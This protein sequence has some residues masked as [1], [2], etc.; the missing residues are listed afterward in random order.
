MKK[1]VFEI[2]MMFLF[3]FGL[4]AQNSNDF[5]D[6]A[7]E[8]NVKDRFYESA[9]RAGLTEA[10]TKELLKIIEERNM[11]LKDLE[12]KKKQADAPYSIQDSGTLYNFK[13]NTARNYYAQKINDFLTY[14]E[15]SEFAMEDYRNEARENTKSEYQLLIA[16]NTGLTESQQKSLYALLYHYHLNQFLTTAY[17]SFD[18][19][20][21]KPKLGILRYSFEKEFK[22]TC[23]E[24]NIKTSSSGNVY[25]NGFEWN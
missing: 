12:T 16:N 8:K 1:K 25:K 18:K 17:Y 15:Y 22:K 19:T 9:K 2:L 24:Y 11:I 4:Q 3:V 14:K 5:M 6:S 21:Q 10:K 20:Q 13:I 23:E 7:V